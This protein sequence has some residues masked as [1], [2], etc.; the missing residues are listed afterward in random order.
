MEL[1]FSRKL[2]ER[3]GARANKLR[4]IDNGTR[5]L[6]RASS[7]LDGFRLSAGHLDAFTCVTHGVFNRRGSWNNILVQPV[8]KPGKV[9]IVAQGFT[10]YALPPAERL[11]KPLSA[12]TR[13]E[14]LLPERPPKRLRRISDLTRG[15]KLHRGIPEHQPACDSRPGPT[16]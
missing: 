3:A 6:A 11:S 8:S 15:Q 4:G 2:R 9:A 14:L 12:R 1:I 16:S 5:E 10:K 13:Y 7:W